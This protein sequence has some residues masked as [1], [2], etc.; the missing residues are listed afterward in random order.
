MPTLLKFKTPLLVLMFAGAAAII[1]SIFVARS[2]IQNASEEIVGSDLMTIPETEVALVLGCSR[3]LSN[4][5]QN[6]FFKYRMDAAVEVFNSGKAEY[7]LVSGDN[8]THSYNEPQDMK[9]ALIERGIPESKIICDYAGFRT[10]DSVVRAKEVFGQDR[11][12]V[13]SQAFHNKRAVFIG[14]S[15]GI[16]I[17]GF[18]A[19]DVDAFSSFKT[20]IREEL[21]RVKTVLDVWILKKEPK[22]LGDPI[23]ITQAH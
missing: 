14:Q 8:H 15:R 10:L 21:A 23:Q 11:L 1:G 3:F 19:R 17:Y 2:V 4:G 12:I 9:D 20:N 6:L 18:N 7:L 22:F 5:R 16:E 13:I